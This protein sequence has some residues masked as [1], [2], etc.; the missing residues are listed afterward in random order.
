MSRS[1]RTAPGP[2]DPGAGLS[3][4]IVHLADGRRVRTV[5]AGESAGPLVVFEAGMS[6]PA[7]E[8]LAVQRGVSARAR[9]LS[10]D[11]SGYGGSD[12]DPQ[13]RTVARMADDL[14]AVLTAAGEHGPVVLVAHSWGGPII[15]AF[16][17][18]HPDRVAGI[19]LVDASLAS[20]T[21][22]R[23]QVVLGRASF[24]ITSLLVRLGAGARVIRMV[25]PHGHASEFSDDDMAIVTRDYASVRAM[26]T[27]V[28]EVNEVLAVGPALREWEAEGLPDVP[29]VALQ[30]GRRE[31]SA[32][33]QRFREE[34]NRNAAELLADHPRAQVVI[35]EGSGHLIPQEQPRAVIDAVLQVAAEAAGS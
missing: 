30:G 3:E 21:V 15:R 11:R 25:L 33:A 23:K 20:S 32:A 13:P 1:D 7:A 10:Y 17:R 29:V 22:T 16:V 9:T 5:V 2:L 28:R 34:F 6:A 19:V 31:K 35:V 14:H 4:N 24:R 27:G 18:N 26:R 8:W 12:D